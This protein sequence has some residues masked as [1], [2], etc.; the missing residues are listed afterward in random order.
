MKKI[1]LTLIVVLLA[2]A[3]C[4]KSEDSSTPGNTGGGD[5][6]T[7]AEVNTALVIKHTGSACPPCGGWGWVA[8]EDIISTNKEN[9]AFMSAY[10]QNFVAKLFITQTATDLDKAWGVSGYPTWSADGMPQ[11]DRPNGGV[12]VTGEKAKVKAEVEAHKAAPVVANTGFTTSISGD[13]MTIKT[14][15]KF[16]K[17]ASGDYRVA[18]YVLEDKVVG[19]QSGHASTP[20]VSHHHVLRGAAK[21]DGASSA[22]T[23]GETVATGSVTAGTEVSKTYTMDVKGFNKDNLEIIVVIWKKDL[24]KYIFVNANTNQK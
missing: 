10:S 17:P 1:Y 12:N 9:A 20:N 8:N 24:G 3:G 4:K 16:F 5:G 14:K 23:W 2:F 13:V 11:L 6:I 15:T 21:L 18:V 22:T 19:A 7:V